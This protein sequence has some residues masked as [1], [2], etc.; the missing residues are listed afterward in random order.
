MFTLLNFFL[1]KF[2]LTS[3][4]SIFG[5]VK[6]PLFW[7]IY[8][9]KKLVLFLFYYYSST[10]MLVQLLYMAWIYAY[11]KAATK[12][13]KIIFSDHGLNFCCWCQNILRIRF[14]LIFSVWIFRFNFYI[15]SSQNYIILILLSTNRK[16]I[17]FCNCCFLLDLLVS[18]ISY[19]QFTIVLCSTDTSDR[20]RVW[21]L[22]RIGVGHQH[23]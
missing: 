14:L 19:K 10:K 23:T 1:R 3:S 22:T 17:Y 2:S 4:S 18:K 7:Q 20:R 5:L 8:S 16:G 11:K 13:C 6:F 9:N 21:W 15:I 12:S